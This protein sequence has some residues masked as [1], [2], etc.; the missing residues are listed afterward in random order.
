M[1]RS[2]LSILLPVYNGALYLE[3]QL[4]SILSQSFADFELLVADDAST[5]ASAEILKTYAA[6]DSRVKLTLHEENA[7]QRMR[8]A[9]LTSR[10]SGELISIADQDDIWAIDR[11]ERLVAAIDDVGLAY[12]T[13]LIIGPDGQPLGHSIFDALGTPPFGSEFRLRFF[14]MSI[15][16][17]HA[18]LIRR[19]SFSPL[20]FSR[21]VPYDW[22]IA[23][24]NAFG[25]GVRHVPDAIVYHRTHGNNQSNASFYKRRQHKISPS[26][27]RVAKR[28]SILGTAR[29]HMLQ[30]LEHLEHSP[31]A[32][33]RL[34]V[35]CRSLREFAS[36]RWLSQISL[37][38][39]QDRE[40]HH[41]FIDGLGPY[42]SS[43][44]DLRL[45]SRHLAVVTRAAWHP[46]EVARYAKAAL[47][48]VF[49]E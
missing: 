27:K 2:A 35:T 46:S 39:A 8:L 11:T 19:S 14:Y 43:E 36:V 18:S 4:E 41:R 38:R 40:L 32:E 7:G 9:E 15:A 22:L 37:P 49:E 3:E 33:R 29:W 30:V 16:S 20:S 31:L 34:R 42:A 48:T 26:L 5:D 25:V 45:F 24:D 47:V 21:S 23:I 28:N 12:G 10:S 6:R 44:E 13:S 1:P 17:G